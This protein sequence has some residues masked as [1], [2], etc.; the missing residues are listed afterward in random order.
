M[1]MFATL[2]DRSLVQIGESAANAG[3]VDRDKVARIADVW[4]TAPSRCSA[5]CCAGRCGFDSG[6][7]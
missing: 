3:F 7:Q 1:S 6:A 5:S 4:T 2:L